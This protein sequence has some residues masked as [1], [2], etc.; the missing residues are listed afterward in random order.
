[1]AEP[2]AAGNPVIF[3]PNFQN[4]NKLDA[5]FLKSSIAGF[6]VN[7]YKELIKNINNLCDLNFYGDCS[8]NAMNYVI[9]HKGSTQKIMELLWQS[10]SSLRIYF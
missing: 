9:K 6:S 7:S 4:S 8:K 1:M 5:V 3:G 2:A 10:F